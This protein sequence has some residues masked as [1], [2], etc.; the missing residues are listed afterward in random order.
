MV[1]FHTLRLNFVCSNFG[2]HLL[3]VAPSTPAELS[4]GLL[5]RVSDSF[6]L[7]EVTPYEIP[8]R[9]VLTS[10]PVL[11]RQLHLLAISRNL[12]FW[13]DRVSEVCV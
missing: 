10:I 2:C 6:V 3:H 1:D 13:D 7:Q 4:Q 8:R 9:T 5:L 11:L 12:F